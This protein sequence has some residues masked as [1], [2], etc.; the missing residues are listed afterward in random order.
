MNFNIFTSA[1][2]GIIH[3]F[4]RLIKILLSYLSILCCIKC[5]NKCLEAS[6]NENNENN[7]AVPDIIISSPAP[8]INN[9]HPILTAYENK[10]LNEIDNI[11]IIPEASPNNDNKCNI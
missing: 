4:F 2:F 10:L 9:E 1:I 3:F 7:G 11:K 5:K 8:L 6:P